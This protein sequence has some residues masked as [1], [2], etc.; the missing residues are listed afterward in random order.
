MTVQLYKA[1]RDICHRISRS[2][3]PGAICIIYEDCYE[4][5]AIIHRYKKN[6]NP[7]TYHTWISVLF[8]LLFTPFSVTFFSVTSQ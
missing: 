6:G 1:L 4:K 7:G 2:N 3:E 5:I 8:S